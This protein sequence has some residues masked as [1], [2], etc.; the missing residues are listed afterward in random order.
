M[1]HFTQDFIDFFKDVAFRS[2]GR[3]CLLLLGC[4]SASVFA[5]CGKSEEEEV[6]ENVAGHYVFRYEKHWYSGSSS[7]WTTVPASWERKE[8]LLNSDGLATVVQENQIRGTWEYDFKSNEDGSV[9]TLEFGP[10]FE[11]LCDTG[12]LIVSVNGD[13][14]TRTFKDCSELWGTVYTTQVFSK[15]F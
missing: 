10:Y 12:P 11:F 6:F 5:G 14:A 7:T 3:I 1:T 4:L 13:S 8:I 9:I 2:R 15:K